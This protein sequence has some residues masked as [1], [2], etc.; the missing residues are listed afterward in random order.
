M[1]GEKKPGSALIN[2]F[3]TDDSPTT[4]NQC[5]AASRISTGPFVPLIGICLGQAKVG[6][7]LTGEQNLSL[8]TASSSA[9][10]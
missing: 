10:N 9:D 2:N 4:L 7:R 5:S 8:Y 1:E 6:I 3:G